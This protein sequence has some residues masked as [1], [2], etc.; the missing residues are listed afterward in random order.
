MVAA[1]LHEPDILARV[2][3]AHRHHHVGDRLEARHGVVRLGVDRAFPSQRCAK[4]PVTTAGD[5]AYPQRHLS[6]PSMWLRVRWLWMLEN[7]LQNTAYY[8]L[9]YSGLNCLECAKWR[10]V[11]PRLELELP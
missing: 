9:L 2:G 11:G 6:D 1:G 10:R 5:R 8:K 3:G 7:T 4:L